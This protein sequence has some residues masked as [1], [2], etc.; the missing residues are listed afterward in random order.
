MT[1]L[2][3]AVASKRSHEGVRPLPDIGGVY[4]FVPQPQQDE[5]GFVSRTL[6]ESSLRAAGIDP[7]GMVHDSTSRTR[8]RAIR[9][10]Y[11]TRGSGEVRLVRC[12]R[13]V[14]FAVVVDLRR[15]SPTLRNVLTLELRAYPPVTLHVPPGCAYGFQSLT[16]PADVHCRTDREIDACDVL[17]IAWD[18]PELRI[19]WP[20]RPQSLAPQGRSAWSLATVLELVG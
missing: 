18:D 13:G 15:D 2:S 5:A 1:T 12:A 10:I 8:Q 9:G 16:E 14:V 20:L 17:T 6:D 3:H 7:A 4:V 19:P 11:L